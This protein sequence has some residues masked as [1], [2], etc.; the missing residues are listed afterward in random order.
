MLIE[1][2]IYLDYNPFDSSYENSK[3][4]FVDVPTECIARTICKR[5]GITAQQMYDI[6]TEFEEFMNFSEYFSE[7]LEVQNLAREFYNVE[8]E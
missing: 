8:E 4:E 7:D 2:E 5:F 3:W 6:L 1:T